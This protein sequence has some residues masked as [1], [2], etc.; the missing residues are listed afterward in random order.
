MVSPVVVG[1]DREL[2]ALL[3][4]MVETPAVVS[5][6]G[7]AGVGKTR[8][9]GELT[10]RPELAGRRVLVGRCQQIRESFPLGPVIEA[11]RGVPS[12]LRGVELSPVAGALRPLLPELADVLPPEPEPLD[13]RVA[14]RHRVFRGLANLLGCLGP[15]VLVLEDL[16]WAEEQTTDFRRYVLADPPPQLV[17]ALTYRTEQVSPAVRAVTAKLPAPVRWTHVELAPLDRDDT[18]GLAASILAV[19]RISGEFT[20]FLWD[21]TSG[22]P[23]AV[24]EVLAV[25]HARGQLLQRRGGEWSRRALQELE[26]PRS[27]RDSTLERV[28]LLSD[29]GRGVAE[30]AAVA[31]T[32]VPLS[33]LVSAVMVDEVDVA[34]EE[35]IGSGLLTEQDNAV[36]FRHLLAAH[37]VYESISGPRRRQLHGRLADSLV[38]Q[39]SAPLGQVAYHLNRAGRLEEWTH[40]AE[41]AAD[42]AVELGND[43][44]AARLLE[45]VLRRARLDPE[46]RGRIAVKLGWAAI[47]TLHAHRITDLLSGVLEQDLARPVRGELRFLLAQALNQTGEE[48]TRQHEL[49]AGAVAD[50]DDRP[51]L[52]AWSMVAL[53]IPTAPG[54]DPSEHVGWL[55][56]AVE[57]AARLGDP[58]L[59]AHILGKAGGAWLQLGGAGWRRAT[60]RVV[61]ITGGAPQRRREVNAYY[62]IGLEACFAGHLQTAELLLRTGLASSG[63]QENRRLEVLLR[64]GL[65]LARYC[66]GAW[67]GLRREVADLVE[68]LAEHP[69]DRLDVE[70]VAGCLAL[71][72]GEVDDAMAQ[73]RGVVT[74]A[75]RI[76]AHQVLPLA[77]GSLARAALA[78]EDADTALG[79][80]HAVLEGLDAKAVWPPVGWVLPSAV[81]ALTVAGRHAEARALI[82]RCAGELSERDAP[83]GQPALRHAYG[84]LDAAEGRWQ[85]ASL[86]LVAARD[87]YREL[88]LPYPEAQAGEAAAAA[89]LQE[90][91]AGGEATLR[92]ALAGYLKLGAAWDHA[93][94]VRLGRRHGVRVARHG[95]GRKGY[96]SELSPQ[97]RKVAE[98]AATGLTNRQIAAELFLSPN[99]VDKHMRAAMRKLG[100]PTRSALAFRLV[101]P[102][103]PAGK[104][105]ELAP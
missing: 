65:A 94:A 85:E 67:D 64:S 5:V 98:L 91:D 81:E 50:L 83:L 96:G 61:E 88:G 101:A 66:R 45:E 103:S 39:E 46:L 78:R 9:V 95:G 73:L 37:A 8:L 89:M 57:Q 53:G 100:V 86:H 44:E 27:I 30:A 70:V 11:V 54:V 13:D 80:V 48:L 23:Y 58:Q 42:R 1:R 32:P 18:G 3:S 68:E 82:T 55:Q 51:D 12:D 59:E 24:E 33:V 43:E 92:S 6:E 10:G 79:C 62:S 28:A 60:D 87:A 16:H 14:M 19:D 36:G 2:A 102:G 47:H 76:A 34:L 26:V 40:A 31:Q 22:L 15:A 41:R 38:A 4:A 25:A 20:R 35:A 52:Q 17:V 7:E 21:C 74:S 29:D 104:N 90:G 71:A 63:A 77:A 93:R 105:G 97:E 84:I 72:S 75:Q 99:T 69:R 49:F 56:R